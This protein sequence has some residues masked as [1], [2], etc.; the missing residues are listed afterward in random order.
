MISDLE[1]TRFSLRRPPPLPP[2]PHFIVRYSRDL[3]PSLLW[4][5]SDHSGASS[6]EIIVYRT[7]VDESSAEHFLKGRELSMD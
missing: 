3:V 7:P 5:I 4:C 1:R 2:L 6:K